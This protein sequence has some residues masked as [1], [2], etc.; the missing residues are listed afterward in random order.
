MDDFFWDETNKHKFVTKITNMLPSVA[1]TSNLKKQKTSSLSSMCERVTE[2]KVVS[3]GWLNDK[4][5][6]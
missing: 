6:N 5:C 4:Y 2:I 1:I 3:H